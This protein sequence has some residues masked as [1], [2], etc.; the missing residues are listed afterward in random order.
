MTITPKNI[1]DEQGRMDK[2][3]DDCKKLKELAIQLTYPG[4]EPAMDWYN[5]FDHKSRTKKSRVI[6]DPTAI[7]AREIWSNGILEI[8]C[9]SR[10][11]GGS[12]RCQT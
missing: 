5:T 2:E 9:R 11:T 7:G 6:Y 12:S 3:F 4:R 10:R 1:I 8:I